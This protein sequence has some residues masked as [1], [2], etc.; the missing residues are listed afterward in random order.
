MTLRPNL[1]C[2]PAS[3]VN[4]PI[5][6]ERINAS[7]VALALILITDQNTLVDIQELGAVLRLVRRRKRMARERLCEG[8]E[9]CHGRKEL[10]V[11]W[12]N[13][14]KVHSVKA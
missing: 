5:N 9:R 3:I 1:I 11:M 10:G 2:L 14:Q 4:S 13:K 12:S 6:G 7:L 8:A